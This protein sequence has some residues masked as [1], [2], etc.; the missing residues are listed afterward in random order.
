MSTSACLHLLCIA[1]AHACAVPTASAPAPSESLLAYQ[2]SVRAAVAQVAPSVV[3]IETVGGQSPRRSS[4]AGPGIPGLS[5]SGG[6]FRIG[7][8]PTTGL[9]FRGD[10]LILT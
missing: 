4:A 6:R 3:T 7:A 10:G 2:E 1:V 8:G 5:E 9:V